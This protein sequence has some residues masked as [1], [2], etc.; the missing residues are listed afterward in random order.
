MVGRK[1]S[2]MAGW[3]SLIIAAHSLLLPFGFPALLC[4]ELLGYAAEVMNEFGV[5]EL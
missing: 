5:Q 2:L 1:G 3:S 4:R